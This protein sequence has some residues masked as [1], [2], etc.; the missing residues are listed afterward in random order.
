MH[1]RTAARFSAPK[2][3]EVGGLGRGLLRGTLRGGP[4]KL[5]R[6]P[7][8]PFVAMPWVKSWKLPISSRPVRRSGWL[9][10]AVLGMGLWASPAW[11]SSEDS[12]LALQIELAELVEQGDAHTVAALRSRADA[13][14]PPAAL[15]AMLDAC[16]EHPSAE[17]EPL[18]RDLAAHRTSAIRAR[19]LLAWAGLGPS[20]SVDAIEA[21]ADDR[22][23]GVRRL[24]VVLARL[25]P[26]DRAD[27]LV[28][29]LL[30]HDPELAHEG[31]QGLSEPDAERE[32]A[33]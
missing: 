8:M 1:E 11:A 33:S 4:L 24:A 15:T 27:A 31:G 13:G 3:G 18:L 12:M 9:C 17:L 21:A 5:W 6:G 25:H 32:E 29:R 20:Q 7:P 19:A 23:G 10:V 2:T 30:E 26:S 22:D 28:A 16:L 14:L